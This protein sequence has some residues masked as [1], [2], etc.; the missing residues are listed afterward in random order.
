MTS[1]TSYT[2][3]ALQQGKYR[4]WVR[5]LDKDDAGITSEL[6]EKLEVVVGSNTAVAAPNDDVD[7]Y[8]EV[9]SL[10]GVSVYKGTDASMPRLKQGCYV[11]RRN[12]ESRKLYIK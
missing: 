6:S 3:T 1:D 12:G 8:I 5:A 10:A 9:Y 7:S 4:C 11:V 2:F